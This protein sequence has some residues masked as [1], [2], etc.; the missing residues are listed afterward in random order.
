MSVVLV[1]VGGFVGDC[2]W[3]CCWLLTVLFK[4]TNSHQNSPNGS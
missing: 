4:P 3:L 2:L 1:V